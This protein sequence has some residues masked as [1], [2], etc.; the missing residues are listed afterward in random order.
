M[1]LKNDNVL[2]HGFDDIHYT[3][4]SNTVHLQK[5]LYLMLC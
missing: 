3:V 1:N 2:A 5:K 4:F